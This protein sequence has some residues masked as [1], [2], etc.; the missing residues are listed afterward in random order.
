MSRLA[1]STR[2]QRA[3][4]VTAYA[5]AV[6]VVAAGLLAVGTPA[7]TAAA[8]TTLTFSYTGAAQTWVVPDGVTSATFDVQGAAGHTI[9]SIGGQGGRSTATLAVTPGAMIT[10]LVGGAGL[11]FNGG[12]NGGGDAAAG[13]GGASDVRLGGT[14]LGDRVLVAGGGGGGGGCESGNGESSTGGAG[15]GT[16]GGDGLATTVCADQFN[17]AGGTA[18]TQST[19]GTNSASLP[20]S[21]A[22]GTGGSNVV[23]GGPISGGGGGGWYGGASG[24]RGGGGGGGSAYGPPGTAFE[25]GVRAGNGVVTITFDAPDPQ[26]ISFGP[27]PTGTSVGS[28]AFQAAATATSGLPVTYSTGAGTTNSACTVS[29]TGLVTIAH[30]GTCQVAADQSGNADFLPAPRAPQSFAVAK[31]TQTVAFTSTPPAYADIGDTFTV[32]AT[33]GASGNPVTFTT[34]SPSICTVT[35]TTVTFTGP[36]Q[37]VVRANQAGSNDYDPAPQ[38]TQTITVTQAQEVRITSTPTLMS[39]LGGKYQVVATATS[40]LP[41]TLATGPATTNGACTIT[42]TTVTLVRNGTCVI[43]ADQPGNN[44]WAPAPQATQ[45]IAVTRAS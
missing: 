19:G 38:V 4:S 28:A 16:V 20:N 44:D 2:P 1:P 12:F 25:T 24:S 29:P 33:G 27:T 26:K 15:G 17:A 45:S 42:G 21:G 43:T 13:G 23:A 6:A 41:V 14:G 5:V 11:R 34:A 18:G 31:A 10:V 37:C 39:T 8:P 40:G 35:G 7:A 36:G 3:R 32:A 30:A 9:G 22:F